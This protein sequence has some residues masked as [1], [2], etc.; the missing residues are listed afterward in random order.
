MLNNAYNLSLTHKNEPHQVGRYQFDW[1]SV[2]ISVAANDSYLFV[3]LSDESNDTEPDH[4]LNVGDRILKVVVPMLTAE[5]VEKIH[6]AIKT[7]KYTNNDKYE[8]RGIKYWFL[9][10]KLNNGMLDHRY[11]IEIPLSHLNI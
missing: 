8:N 10:H 11:T 3:D 5:D 2:A 4:L 7:K 6:Q 9:E 1:N